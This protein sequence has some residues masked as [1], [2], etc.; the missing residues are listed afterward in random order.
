MFNENNTSCLNG[1]LFM[2]YFIGEGKYNIQ[3][4][5]IV[6]WVKKE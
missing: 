1:T 5:N 4:L 2:I 3:N 6:Y